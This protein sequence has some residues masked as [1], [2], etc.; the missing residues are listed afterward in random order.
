[1]FGYKVNALQETPTRFHFSLQPELAP[2]QVRMTWRWEMQ[3]RDSARDL[4]YN[5]HHY[6]LIRRH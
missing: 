6:P 4:N 3:N 2:W 1:M 5:E